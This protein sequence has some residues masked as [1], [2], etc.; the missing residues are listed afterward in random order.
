MCG[1]TRTNHDQIQQDIA[2]NLLMLKCSPRLAEREK[3]AFKEDDDEWLSGI[4]S[5]VSPTSPFR[6]SRTSKTW[7]LDIVAP[8]RVAV[9]FDVRVMESS[10][11]GKC[12]SRNRYADQ[13]YSGGHS[14]PGDYDERAV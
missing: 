14:H 9:S 8:Y 12:C 13:A 11:L 5:R 1:L 7:A 4:V 2:L 10:S 3:T 6:V